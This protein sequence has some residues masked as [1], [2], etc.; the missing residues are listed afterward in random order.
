[1][2]SRMLYGENW[3]IDLILMSN[4]RVFDM[5]Y[6]YLIS[7]STKPD[8]FVLR[9]PEGPKIL[10][11]V[12]PTVTPPFLPRPSRS[13][14]LTPPACMPLIAHLPGPPKGQN[15][16]VLAPPI[17]EGSGNIPATSISAFPTHRHYMLKVAGL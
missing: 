8:E 11:Q 5:R 7:G 14:F 9:K 17:L 3:L 16:F 2:C 10:E 4:K 12:P 15:P 1:V 13:S 6:I